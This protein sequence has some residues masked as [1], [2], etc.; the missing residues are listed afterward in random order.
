M[1]KAEN[2]KAEKNENENEKNSILLVIEE[3]DKEL[4]NEE[5]AKEKTPTVKFT[6][7]D[8]NKTIVFTKKA[9]ELL[10]QNGVNISK[11]YFSYNATPSVYNSLEKLVYENKEKF[12]IINK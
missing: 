2:A 9:V 10:K 4:L 6:L 12:T 8:K 1:Q 3:K 5:L 7:T 11:N